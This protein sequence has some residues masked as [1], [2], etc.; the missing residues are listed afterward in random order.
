MLRLFRQISGFFRPSPRP[1]DP[2][3]D[4]CRSVVSTRNRRR[5]ARA[6]AQHTDTVVRVPAERRIP[7]DPARVVPYPV[8]RSRSVRPCVSRLEKVAID[9]SLTLPTAAI[10]EAIL[11]ASDAPPEI[12]HAVRT[13][14]T[15]AM[16]KG[17]LAPE[18]FRE[19]LGQMQIRHTGK[20]PQH[21]PGFRTGA[22]SRRC[23]VLLPRSNHTTVDRTSGQPEGTAHKTEGFGPP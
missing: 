7:D 19:L 5:L 3:P 21:L 11:R 10:V 18:P 23:R 8:L 13:L 4:V 17:I 16:A 12:V 1:G 6:L 20:K 9:P 2:D 15:E 14:T 22:R